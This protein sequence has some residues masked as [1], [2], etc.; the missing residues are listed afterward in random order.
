M[1]KKESDLIKLFTRKLFSN[2]HGAYDRRLMN[3]KTVNMVHKLMHGD[4][5]SAGVIELAEIDYAAGHGTL[6]PA[7]D[8]YPTII[9]MRPGERT[10]RKV[11]PPWGRTRHGLQMAMTAW[12]QVIAYFSGFEPVNLEAALSEL[13]PSY[14]GGRDNLMADGVAIT[15][16]LS[17]EETL[18]AVPFH[19]NRRFDAALDPQLSPRTEQSLTFYALFSEEAFAAY[20]AQKEAGRTIHD[21]EQQFQQLLWLS[22]GGEPL[23]A[24]RKKRP[25]R[26]RSPYRPEQYYLTNRLRYE[27]ERNPRDDKARRSPSRQPYRRSRSRSRSRERPRYARRGHSAQRRSSDGEQGDVYGR[28]YRRHGNGQ[29]AKDADWRNASAPKEEWKPRQERSTLRSESPRRRDRSPSRDSRVKSTRVQY[30]KR[31]LKG[32]KPS[33]FDGEKLA[34]AWKQKTGKEVRGLCSC[35]KPNCI[36][37]SSHRD[38][39]LLPSDTRLAIFNSIPLRR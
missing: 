34:A 5:L 24:T 35:K 25:R 23:S 28:L 37:A 31:D 27:E 21:L 1:I 15:L 7:H 8:T 29:P 6:L 26:S 10:P 4:M 2:V 13:V 17:V 14:S 11:F 39:Q 22:D 33:M 32:L 3:V 9:Y 12:N 18:M 30:E 19:E 16:A 20:V 38:A 36:S